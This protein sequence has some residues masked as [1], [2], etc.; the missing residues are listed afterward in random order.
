MTG[1]MAGGGT[2]GCGTGWIACR[3]WHAKGK[4]RVCVAGESSGEYAALPQNDKSAQCKILEIVQVSSAP[5]WHTELLMGVSNRLGD[6]DGKLLHRSGA[7]TDSQ[8]QLL[9]LRLR[10]THC[11]QKWRRS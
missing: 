2:A 1:V 7:G 5:S 8:K 6:V 4:D 10:Q 11:C 3:A 9:R